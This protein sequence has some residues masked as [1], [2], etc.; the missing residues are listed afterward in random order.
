MFL[1]SKNFTMWYFLLIFLSRSECL[2]SWPRDCQAGSGSGEGSGEHRETK[3]V[4]RGREVDRESERARERARE[5][6]SESERERERD[7]GLD[8]HE[9]VSPTHAHGQTAPRAGPHP[10][11]LVQRLEA[12]LMLFLDLCGHVALEQPLDAPY[13]LLDRRALLRPWLAVL[14]GLATPAPRGRALPATRTPAGLEG[15]R[16]DPQPC[17]WGP[18]A[19]AAAGGGRSHFVRT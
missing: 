16:L 6:K 11:F 9:R 7:V 13:L 19:A 8:K 5:I 14:P 1:R 3:R 10:E 15:R 17:V 2:R 18:R 4:S 12:R